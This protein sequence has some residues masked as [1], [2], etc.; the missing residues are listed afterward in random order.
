MKSLNQYINEGWKEIQ[1]KI[2]FAL[3]VCD[4]VEKE[5]NSHG[6]RIVLNEREN[7]KSSITNEKYSGP[8][9]HFNIKERKYEFG[10]LTRYDEFVLSDITND[11][12]A[13]VLFIKPNKSFKQ[14]IDE[15]HEWVDA[16]LFKRNILEP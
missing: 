11:K 5:L 9:V 10:F 8:V 12:L 16:K 13:C 1:Q 6:T 15:I 3:Q 7:N 14:I 4:A 2:E